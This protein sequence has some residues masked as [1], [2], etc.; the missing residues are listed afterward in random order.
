MHSHSIFCIVPPI[1]FDRIARD[2][3]PT[4]REWA[5]DTLSRDHSLRAA[6]L[7][8]AILRAG[9]PLHPDALATAEAG[10]P[11]RTIYD[12]RGTEQLPG[13]PVCREGD[14]PGDDEIAMKEAYDGLGDTY[15]YYW[16]AHDRDSI[17]DAGMP[18]EG[19]IHYGQNYD[20]AFWDSQRMIFGDGDGEL[21]NRFTIALDVIGHELTH[22]VTEDEAGLNYWQQSGALNESISDVFGSL[23]KQYK[24]G[25]T[26]DEADWLIGEGLLADGVQGRALRSM[27]E[28]GTAYDD[29]ILGKDPQPAHMDNYV[30]TTADNGGVHVNSGIPNHAFYLVASELGGHA[31]EKAGAIWYSAL[32]DPRLQP[33]A[34]FS[35]FARTTARAARRLFGDDS[36]EA[37]AV[38]TAWDSVG[39]AVSTKALAAAHR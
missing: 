26:A 36:D 6:R 16:T 39:V 33:T 24:R 7:Q 21:F 18:L 32:R 37:R 23:I 15:A 17:D 25:Q 27:A 13:E 30:H 8:N 10:K 4:Q 38:A 34:R 31:W 9:G 19:V 20:N 11:K 35:T 1:I 28:P 22:G 29:D 3:S 12:A 14:T 2:G 5:L